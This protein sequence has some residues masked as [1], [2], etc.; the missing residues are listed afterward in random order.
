VYYLSSN[1]KSSV[2]GLYEVLVNEESTLKSKIRLIKVK[3]LQSN[4]EF[5][6]KHAFEPQID[7]VTS[8]EQL[9]L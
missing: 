1:V 6:N 2:E 8:I 3:S 4:N 7:E 9:E 5:N